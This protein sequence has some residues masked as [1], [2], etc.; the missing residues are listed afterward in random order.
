[1]QTSRKEPSHRKP[2]NL[3]L[4]SE[5]LHEAKTLGINISR[6]AEAGIEAAVRHQ[7]Q[8]DWLKE[9]TAA[10]ESSN[11]YV[12]KNGLPLLQYRQF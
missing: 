4:D 8:L 10:L 3:S 9:N 12:E 5:L 1:M 7:K 2:T 11:D 6:S